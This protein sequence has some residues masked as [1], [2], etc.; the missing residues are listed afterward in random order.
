MIDLDIAFSPV[1]PVRGGDPC[2]AIKTV[3]GG[4]IVNHPIIQGSVSPEELKVMRYR[5]LT[6]NEFNNKKA[7]RRCLGI[8][9]KES[10]GD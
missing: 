4:Y 8:D 1:I 10:N 5:Y 3:G 7:I 6:T 2:E 9:K